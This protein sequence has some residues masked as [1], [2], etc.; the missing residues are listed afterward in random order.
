MNL[1]EKLTRVSRI[2]SIVFYVLFIVA[3]VA[4]A[5]TLLGMIIVPAV[6]MDNLFSWVNVE[7]TYGITTNYATS[8]LA[9]MTL[10]MA[11]IAAVMWYGRALFK[12]IGI[13]NTPFSDTAVV[14]LRMLG[15]GL[16]VNG[17]VP[18]VLFAILGA[19]LSFP[20]DATVG[21][22]YAALIAG[23][24]FF[25]LSYVFK[26]GKALQNESDTTL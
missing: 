17:I 19:A 18:W 3:T 8:Y 4:T 15:A 20:Q 16:I 24:L 21:G 12:G 5:L 25:G 14:N 23:L 10:S 26:Y 7:N 22:G 11:S 9:G 1:K 2:F 13:A 6:G